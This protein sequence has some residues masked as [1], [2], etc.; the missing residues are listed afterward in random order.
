MELCPVSQ[1]TDWPFSSQAWDQTPPVVQ[2]YLR[3]MQDELTQFR[4]RMETLAAQRKQTSMT[5]HR[6]PSSDS[7]YQRPRQRTASVTPRTA[8]GKSGHQGHGPV[9]LPPTTVRELTPKRCPCG[10][11]VFAM[12]TPYHTHQV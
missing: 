8:R 4:Q 10:N 11:T 6:P 3:T 9:R 1:R 5:S 12:T 7:P 2:A